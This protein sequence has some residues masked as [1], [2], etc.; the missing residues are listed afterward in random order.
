MRSEVSQGEVSYVA[1]EVFLALILVRGHS[2]PLVNA[3]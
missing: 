1:E 2:F 3:F